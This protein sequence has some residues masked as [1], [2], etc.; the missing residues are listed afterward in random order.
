MVAAKLDL[1]GNLSSTLKQLPAI[2]A[3]ANKLRKEAERAETAMGKANG[4]ISSAQAGL[5]RSTDALKQSW[6][7]FA[8]EVSKSSGSL[9]S[10]NKTNDWFPHLKAWARLID[11]CD[12]SLPTVQATC[13]RLSTL[14]SYAT[15]L[16]RQLEDIVGLL[17]GIYGHRLTGWADMDVNNVNSTLTELVAK[18]GSWELRAPPIR[19]EAI[20]LKS[21]KVSSGEVSW[22]YNKL[23]TFEGDSDPNE[24]TDKKNIL[25]GLTRF[26][27]GRERMWFRDGLGS[28]ELVVDGVKHPWGPNKQFLYATPTKED[29]LYSSRLSW[30][31]L[32]QELHARLRFGDVRT[33]PN[34][35]PVLGTYAG[36]T[37][38]R[39]QVVNFAV[40]FAS[41]NISIAVWVK[42]AIWAS[43]AI[44]IEKLNVSRHGFNLVLH[45]Y[46][47]PR[48]AAINECQVGWMAYELSPKGGN[49]DQDPKADIF[50]RRYRYTSPQ[51]S[52]VQPGS[53]ARFLPHFIPFPKGK[54]SRKPAVATLISGW[55]LNHDTNHRID[56]RHAVTCD[57]IIVQAL[58]WADTKVESLTAEIIAIAN[59]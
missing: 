32:P 56:F 7:D 3:A 13:W 55:R 39:S 34:N 4:Q 58:S 24:R 46:D 42:S 49:K 28:S 38:A 29:H 31:L 57:G 36:F 9:I 17:F 11:M 48:V 52:E 14:S 16:R 20:H 1:R 40:P 26:D 27:C 45:G 35:P 47:F 33:L 30:I 25:Y 43:N 5:I 8:T 10:Q 41:D 23:P 54:F 50:S 21:P 18:L 51:G 37:S 59:S 2:S 19:S 53:V 22:S 15:Q 12:Y 44:Q 6:V